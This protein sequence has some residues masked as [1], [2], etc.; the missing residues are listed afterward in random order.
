M[1]RKILTAMKARSKAQL[2][3]RCWAKSLQTQKLLATTRRLL[4]E[5]AA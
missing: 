1:K 4:K 5:I 2:R 3:R